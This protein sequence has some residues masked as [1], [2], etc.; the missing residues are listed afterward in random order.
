MDK[1]NSRVHSFLFFQIATQ[2][3]NERQEI[4]EKNE[5]AKEVIN[6]SD[7]IIFYDVS[8]NFALMR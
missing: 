5:S 3:R 1:R 8:G 2:M 6:D 7:W 4:C